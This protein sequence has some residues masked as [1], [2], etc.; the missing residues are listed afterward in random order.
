[1]KI[2]Y[3]HVSYRIGSDE[4]TEGDDAEYSNEDPSDTAV[5]HDYYHYND[6]MREPQAQQRG[7]DSGVDEEGEGE[8][9]VVVEING[10]GEETKEEEAESKVDGEGGYEFWIF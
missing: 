7:A 1:M 3:P 6:D 9:V 5:S 8:Q 10:G 4:D 2:L